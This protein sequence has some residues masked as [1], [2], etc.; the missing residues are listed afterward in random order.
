VPE[1]KTKVDE[2]KHKNLTV[3]PEIWKQMSPA[4]KEFYSRLNN[5]AQREF[6]DGKLELAGISQQKATTQKPLPANN[7]NVSFTKKQ[8]QQED[9]SVLGKTLETVSLQESPNALNG[10]LPLEV[11]GDIPTV[12][13]LNGSKE[14]AGHGG[15]LARGGH[16]ILVS[17]HHCFKGLN[18]P[19]HIETNHGVI[20][21]IG[22]ILRKREDL[23]F[24]AL[25]EQVQ[26]VKH[27][28]PEMMPPHGAYCFLTFWS[29][30]RKKWVPAAGTYND[31]ALGDWSSEKGT[32]GTPVINLQTQGCPGVH[33]GDA[34]Q[35]NR[36]VNLFT[37]EDI[38]WLSQ[39]G[40]SSLV[41]KDKP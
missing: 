19:T 24:C 11:T 31:K 12:R 29:M 37:S 20:V 26:K 16:H 21:K 32:S 30:T 36:D 7:N 41:L 22:S 9:Y 1:R 13:L 38:L 3:P 15:I 4:Q 39:S 25:E 35:D 34:N 27:I 5:S 28:R 33:F 23:V 6:I 40:D 14:F 2:L 18:P 8:V 10:Y 17:A